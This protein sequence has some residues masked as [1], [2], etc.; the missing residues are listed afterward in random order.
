[1]NF[2]EFKKEVQEWPV[3]FTRDVISGIKESQAVR[4]Q[5]ERWRKRG[6]LVRLKKGAFILA[7]Y[8][9]KIDPS[10]AY[11]ANQLYSPSYVSLEYALNY[12]GLIPERVSDVTSITTRKTMRIKNEVG[13]FLYQHINPKAF[14][15]FGALKDEAGLPF[16]IAEPEKAVMDFLY[17]NL[18]KF[19]KKDIAVF[20]ESYRFQNLEKMSA[21]R[22]VEFANLFENEKLTRVARLFCNYLKKGR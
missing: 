13:L 6:L 3:I 9:R 22:I 5:L 20:G 7:E 16:F 4:N 11:L 17:L 15:G 1:M 18:D 2:S 14:R 12:Y 21:K 8:D 19:N 10:R